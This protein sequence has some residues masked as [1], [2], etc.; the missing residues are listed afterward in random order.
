[1]PIADSQQV[2]YWFIMTDVRSWLAEHGFQQHADLF[3]KNE[4]DGEVL[5]DLTNDDLKELGLSLGQR[6]KLLKAIAPASQPADQPKTRQRDIVSPHGERRQVTVL[7]ADLAGF[8][9]L[10]AS[11]DP[12]ETHRLLNAYFS[13]VD[14]IIEQH[15][16]TV[17]KHIGDAVMAVFGAPVA[18]SDDPLRALRAASGIHGAMLDLEQQFSRELKA[19]IGI[20][21]GVVVASRTGSEQHTEY[22]VT[23]DTVNLASRLDDLAAPGETLVSDAVHR[24][25]ARYAEFSPRGSTSI[26]GLA[27]PVQVWAFEHLLS[28]ENTAWLTRFIGRTAEMRQFRSIIRDTLADNSGQ[29][30]LLRGEP[31]IGKTRLTSEFANL[32]NQSG[33]STHNV[34]MVDFG[35]NRGARTLLDLVA[36]LLELPA[37]SSVEQRVNARA[38]ALDEGYVSAE[39]E[40]FLNDLLD[41]QQPDQSRSAYE[42]LDST[43]RKLGIETTLSTL[44]V[45]LAHQIPRLII[46]EDVHWADPSTLDTLAGAALK[47]PDCPAIFVLTSRIEG[48]TL[49]QE[50]LSS[51]RGCSLTTIDLQSLRHDDAMR[52]ASSLSD[53][54]ATSLENLVKRADGNPLFLEQLISGLSIYQGDEL[55]D[56]I[57]GLVLARADNL[58]PDDREALFAASALGQRFRLDLLRKLIGDPSYRSDNL[59]KHQLLRRDGEDHLFCHALVRDGLY[60]SMLGD[61]R[62]GLHLRAASLYRELDPTMHAQHLDRAESKDAA[63]AYLAAAQYEDERIHYEPAL[64]LVLRGI[65]LTSGEADYELYFLLGDLQR[66]LGNIGEAIDAFGAARNRTSDRVQKCRAL[67]G[68]AEGLRITESYPELLDTLKTA[69]QELEDLGAPRERARICQLMGSLHFVHGETKQCLSEN[70]RSLAFAREAGSRELEAQALGN[71]ADAEFARGR[72]VSAHRLFDDCVNLAVKHDLHNV[73]AANLSMKGQT[74]LYLGRPT[75]TLDDCENALELA[76]RQFNPRAELVARL[77]GVYALELY[78]TAVCREW[79]EAGVTLARRLGATRF[80]QVCVEYLGRLAAIDG[81]GQEAERLVAGTLAAFRASDSSMR[82]LGGRALGSFALVCQHPAQRKAALAEGEELLGQG[83]AAHNPLWFYRDAIEVSL[84]LADWQEVVRFARDLEEFTSA[85]PLRWSSYFA[86]RGR[87]LA[88][89]AQGEDAMTQLLSVRAEG[90]SIGFTHSLA[91]MDAAISLSRSDVSKQA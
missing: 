43:A 58:P 70:N 54:D 15:G 80:E 82:F 84:D 72:M 64:Q 40:I 3:E 27:D 38:Q 22:T 89:A 81:D 76:V 19:H 63:A 53:S 33:L 39:N 52:L 68:V 36:S 55:P 88:K 48:G 49:H 1:M 30:L 71:L 11:L 44:V 51:L 16:G 45:N 78:D 35:T 46:V 20:A 24:V 32:A 74:L 79:A 2:R 86:A 4:I 21:S 65:E 13:A 60:A 47:L 17:D 7:F 31:G 59:T 57:Q 61:R 87:A 50:W 9:G 5:F 37:G 73:T 56:T 69:L 18:H 77:V 41:L 25:L 8:T 85:E 75:E 90:E 83:V 66:R 42:A 6:K 23:G 29:V 12:E 14:Y 28:E 34:S 67:I 62:K 10:T 26:K 91:R